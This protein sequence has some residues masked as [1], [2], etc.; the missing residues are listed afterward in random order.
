MWNYGVKTYAKDGVS[1]VERIYSCLP[2]EYTPML[3]TKFHLELDDTP[4]LGLDDH[5]KF[6]M[7]LGMLQ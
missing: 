1:C 2:N 3:V 4:L 7:L 5:C 6:Q